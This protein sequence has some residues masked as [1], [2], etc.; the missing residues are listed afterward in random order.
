VAQPERKRHTPKIEA[1]NALLL[2]RY[3]RFK[4]TPESWQLAWR[5]FKQ[6]VELDPE[7]AEAHTNLAML[8]VVEWALDV[9]E[10]R[11]TIEA[12]RRAAQKALALDDSQAAAHA[13][14]G[15]IHAVD[16]YNWSAAEQDFAR[17]LQ[18]DPG[19]A[20]VLLLYGYWFLRPRGRLHEA[21]AQY[22]RMLEMDPLSS[23]TLF[24]I[25]EAYFF[26]DKFSSVI[27]Y[28]RKALEIDPG[29]WPPLTMMA[30]SHVFLGEPERAREWIERAVALAPEDLTVRSISAL[31]Q[32]IGGNPG[33]ARL[34]IAELE[35]RSG[36]ARVPAML[37][38]L[39]DAVGD[40][41]AAFRC[42][43]EMIEHRSARVFWIMCPTYSNLRRH[44]RFPELLRRM[45]LD[46][47]LLLQATG[48]AGSAPE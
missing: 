46:P 11:Q 6:A 23:F 20:D 7:Y 22:R 38:M 5:S 40:V 4:F 27:E 28:S 14:L 43:E 15:T 9:F 35:S 8:H 30:S 18:L 12:A 19:S 31:L 17:A 34:L 24:T 33:P 48:V 1:Y 37:A 47:S 10:P 25:A 13:I 3:H 16:D 26:E 32:L 41:E 44:P 39:Y 36:W 45:N 21:R 42:A 2:G 29:Y